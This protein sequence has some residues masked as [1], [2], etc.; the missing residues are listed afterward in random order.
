LAAFNAATIL[1][2]SSDFADFIRVANNYG[3]SA[4]NAVHNPT[5]VLMDRFGRF[6]PAFAWT[7]R[8]LGLKASHIN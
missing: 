7:E 2:L 3:D 1:R 8:V 6:R 5:I 4:L